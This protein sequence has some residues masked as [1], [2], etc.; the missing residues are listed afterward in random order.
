MYSQLLGTYSTWRWGQWICLI[1]NAIGTA[2]LVFTYFPQSQVRAHGA[3]W[4]DA[5]AKI[6]YLGA[7]LSITGLT[8]L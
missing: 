1:W 8:I 3:T 6:D 2:G 4:K 5:A 7:L